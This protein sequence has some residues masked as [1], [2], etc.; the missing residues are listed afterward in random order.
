MVYC[1]GALLSELCGGGSVSRRHSVRPSL[2]MPLTTVDSLTLDARR[3]LD[4]V[5]GEESITHLTTSAE[6]RGSLLRCD[7]K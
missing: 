1:F 6:R 2:S 7:S 5:Y 4:V 3:V